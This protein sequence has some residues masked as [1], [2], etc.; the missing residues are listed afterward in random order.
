MDQDL[1][2]PKAHAVHGYTLPVCTECKHIAKRGH[3]Y[4][5]K[6]RATFVKEKIRENL[7]A[8]LQTPDWSPEEID[9]VGRNMRDQ[10]AAWQKMR[11]IAKDRIAW[12][13][14]QYLK[15]I[16]E[17]CDFLPVY[18]ESEFLEA[19]KWRW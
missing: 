5:F 16:D 6:E 1:F 4:D 10:I 2:P 11:E 9:E 17:T 8:Q 13:A 14:I 18:S 19:N 12:N 3:P 7:K 15:E